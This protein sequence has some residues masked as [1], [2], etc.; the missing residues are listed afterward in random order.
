MH[1]IIYILVLLLSLSSCGSQKDEQTTSEVEKIT[2]EEQNVLAFFSSS[3]INISN[4]SII[5]LNPHYCG[6]CTEETIN[7]IVNQNQT[8]S[9]HKYVLTTGDIPEEHKPQL[10]ATSFIIVPVNGKEVGRLG[11]AETASTHF[12]LKN[13]RIELEEIIK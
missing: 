5:L 12:L 8:F 6:A 11:I 2:Q 4:S 7:W 3:G 9:G 1:R 10:D 13:D